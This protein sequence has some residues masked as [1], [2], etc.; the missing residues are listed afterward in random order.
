MPATVRSPC[1]LPVS[2]RQ[3]PCDASAELGERLAEVAGG[4]VDAL[5]VLDE[6]EADVAVATRT[7]AD[8][9][10]Q[11]D[12]GLTYEERRELDRAHLAVGL[13]DRRPGEHRA[14]GR[15]DVPADA[16]EAVA[17]RVPTRL[18]D[19]QHLARV[20]RR[21]VERDRGRDLDRLERAVVEVRLELG[22]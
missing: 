10:R 15:L 17:Q 16:L 21:L 4:L 5:L 19:R 20:V 18:G 3:R 1:E 6:R 12:L 2:G 14:L 13:G 22:E 8:A 7:E 11:R 9:G